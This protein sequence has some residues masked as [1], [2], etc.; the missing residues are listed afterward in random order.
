MV[1]AL[2]AAAVAGAGALFMVM[3][4]GHFGAPTVAPEGCVL[5]TGTENIG[6]PIA[7]VDENG[8]RVTQADFTEGPSV[9]YFG[10]THCP[11][12]CPTTMYTLAEAMAQPGGYDLQPVMITVDPARDTPALMRQ[13]VHTEGFPPGLVGLS[14]SVA[15]VDAAADAFKVVHSQSA[16]EGRPA[17]DYTVNH[18]SFLY[19]MDAQW[20]TRALMPTQGASP[21]DIAQCI[22]AGLEHEPQQLARAG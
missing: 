15:Q 5:M 12:I 7:L 21:Q 9:V 17:S 19:V 4:N 1:P 18:S 16:L 20:R 13:Y 8:T 10:F 11:D 3:S 22:A 14:G 2:A 6:G